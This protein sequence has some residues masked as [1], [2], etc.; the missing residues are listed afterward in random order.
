MAATTTESVETTVFDAL[1]EFGAEEDAITRDATF[2]AL[3]I[4]SLDLAELAQIVDEQYGVT[5]K[6]ADVKELKTVGDAIDLIVA[7][8]NA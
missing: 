3:E 2:E 4:D 5:L 1:K 6:G 7:R 8:S